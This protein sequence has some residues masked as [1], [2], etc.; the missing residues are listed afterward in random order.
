[1][2]NGVNS[3]PARTS[4]LSIQ[5]WIR[6]WV[7]RALTVTGLHKVLN[8]LC[9]SPTSMR[10]PA[11]WPFLIYKMPVP[12]CCTIMG[13]VIIKED[14][15]LD[16]HVRVWLSLFL[17]STNSRHHKIKFLLKIMLTSFLQKITLKLRDFIIYIQNIIIF[18]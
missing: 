12:S 16:A 9:G 14:Y 3:K 18:I 15:K 4:E 8:R 6:I 17:F 10:V 13:L 2:D 5:V 7:S 1:M 11:A